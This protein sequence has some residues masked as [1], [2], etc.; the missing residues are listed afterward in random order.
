MYFLSTKAA[1]SGSSDRCSF[2]S[3]VTALIELWL[4]HP[5]AL[6]AGCGRSARTHRDPVWDVALP[7]AGTGL[8]GLGAQVKR[9]Q[10]RGGRRGAQSR[11]CPPARRRE[12]SGD[13]EGS[14]DTARPAADDL[15]RGPGRTGI[16]R[17]PPRPPVGR[18]RAVG[19][20]RRAGPGRWRRRR[21]PSPRAGGGRGP[22]SRQAALGCAELGAAPAGERRTRFVP[23]LFTQP[24]GAQGGMETQRGRP[25]GSARS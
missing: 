9:P 12:S 23:R 13:R 22:R 8:A 17:A 1:G 6:K 19:A 18:V 7:S 20:P 3:S 4:R 10:G 21:G 5:P 25:R 24:G 16:P 15:G 14:A 2:R 11:H